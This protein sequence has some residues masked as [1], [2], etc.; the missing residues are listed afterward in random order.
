MKHI[1]AVDQSTSASK[2]FLVDERG[3]I[4]RRATRPHKRQDGSSV[5]SQPYGRILDREDQ[6]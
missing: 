3:E 2:A 4:A 1:V 5:Q 6:R